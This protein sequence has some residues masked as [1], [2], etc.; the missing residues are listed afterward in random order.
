MQNKIMLS[1][2]VLILFATSECAHAQSVAWRNNLQRAAA[3]SSKSQ[4][5]ILLD[6]T[7][8]WCTYCKKMKKTYANRDISR[9][10]NSCFIP[11]VLDADQN[12]K[13]MNT[14]GVEALPATII[15]SPKF[16]VVKKIVGYQTPAEL[17]REIG[18]FCRRAAKKK[19]IAQ[20][21]TRPASS[22][23][24]TK[25]A[26]FAFKKLCLVTLLEKREMKYGNT[27]FASTFNGQKVCFASA[28]MKRKFDANPAKYWPVLNGLDV[29]NYADKRM[30]KAGNPGWV[31]IYRDRIWFFATDSERQQ[32]AKTPNRYTA[33]GLRNI[34][35]SR[36]GNSIRH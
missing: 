19:Q 7:A 22:K 9:Q 30:K 20:R 14:L 10:I 4:K 35:R 29:V 34:A 11:V 18:K 31:A 17:N 25:P 21:T 33:Y 6:I 15:I 26:P 2:G 3:E 27:K 32:F 36:T 16:E 5:P 24:Q 12:Q 1:L 28:E 13:L 8:T 23:K